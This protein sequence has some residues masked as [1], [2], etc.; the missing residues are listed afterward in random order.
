MNAQL[1]GVLNSH[2]NECTAEG[3]IV[4]A[5][6][7]RGV[8]TCTYAYTCA[9][10]MATQAR[11]ALKE[12]HRKVVEDQTSSEMIKLLLEACHKVPLSR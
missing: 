5:V 9:S 8:M 4:C 7:A 1:R 6:Q 2:F 10:C 11:G 12:L 3:C